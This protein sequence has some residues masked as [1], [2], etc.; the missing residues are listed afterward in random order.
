MGEVVVARFSI[1]VVQ[2]L[3]QSNEEYESDFS[4]FHI[5][6]QGNV[7]LGNVEGMPTPRMLKTRMAL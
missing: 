5:E 1:F 3:F 7:L 2:T 4:K 6:F